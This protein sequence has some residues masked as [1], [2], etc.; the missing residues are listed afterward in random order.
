MTGP[1]V[2][3]LACLL[4]TRN[5]SGLTP[6][7]IIRQLPEIW[8]A[9]LFTS[10][11][12]TAIAGPIMIRV[13]FAHRVRQNTRVQISAITTLRAKDQ[14]TTDPLRPCRI[15]MDHLPYCTHPLVGIGTLTRFT[16]QSDLDLPGALRK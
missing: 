8:H 15:L 5:F 10:A 14:S 7:P 4:V 16:R 6:A 9:I 3:I 12:V 1:A 2:F 11:A 13:I